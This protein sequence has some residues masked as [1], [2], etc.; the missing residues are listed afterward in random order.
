[1]SRNSELLT[2]VLANVQCIT[3]L[4]GSQW[5]LVIRQA[6]SAVLL[7]RLASLTKEANLLETV[8][9]GPRRHLQSAARAGAAHGL[10][11]R[12]ETLLLLDS[13]RGVTP[14]V[15]LKG[16]AYEFAGLPTAVG[17]LF[18]DL[19]ILVPR[20]KLEEV[21]SALM[22]RGW[23]TMSRNQYDQRYYRRWMHE[24]PPMQHIGRGTVLDVH[25]A[26][27]PPTGRIRADSKAMLAAAI[28]VDTDEAIFVLAPIDMLLH[29]ATHLFQEG[30]LDRGLRDLVDIDGLL[31]HYGVQPGFWERIV[32]RALEI[33]VT[34]P[35]FYALRYANMILGTPVPHYVMSAA[36]VGA[37]M[38]P[39]LGLMDFLYL[40]ALR[41]NHPTSS[42]AHTPV[43]RWMLYVRS[44]WLRM[45][46]GMLAYH[47]A[48]K[49]LVRSD[50]TT[51][52]AADQ[53]PDNR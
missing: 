23:V 49:A 8:P 51:E 52:A 33:G 9:E 41:P 35:L 34:R 4:D 11:V 6:R 20:D 12:R 42:D 3:E 10:S 37:P 53:V 27:S 50:R 13:V 22:L 15:L 25:H 40:R 32:P 21:E 30:E 38:R 43:A 48:R 14:L 18:N 24:L 2:R 28:P 26:V 1:M 36:K 17:R 19:D 46:L 39:S 44:H 45:P 16:A 47:L 29:S 5:D 31:R 7:S